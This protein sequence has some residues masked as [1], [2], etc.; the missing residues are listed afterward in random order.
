MLT[1]VILAGGENRRMNG[2]VKAFLP[3]P[4]EMLILRQLR[5]LRKICSAVIIVTNKPE[6]YEPVVCSSTEVAVDLMPGLGPLS[7]IHTALTHANTP[8]CWIAACDMPFIDA[9][10]TELMLTQIRSSDRA[11]AVPILDG[12]LHPLH[13]IYHKRCVDEADVL[14]KSGVYAVKQLL[15]KID[16]VPLTELFYAEHH[17]DVRFVTNMNTPEQYQEVLAKFKA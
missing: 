12:K 10:A 11:A 5:E 4:E 6:L 17:I 14:L 1:G 8:Y 2:V 7:G 15:R 9:N 16:W 3:C 13:G